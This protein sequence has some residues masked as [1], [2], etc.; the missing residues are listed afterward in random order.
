MVGPAGAVASR[1][2]RRLSA[3]LVGVCAQSLVPVPVT[4]VARG[5]GAADQ[6]RARVSVG[7]PQGRRPTRSRACGA[8]P[9]PRRPDV[10]SSGSP[11]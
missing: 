1:G 5:L 7:W 6:P 3:M 2:P 10:V 4:G 8:R 11:S 9:G